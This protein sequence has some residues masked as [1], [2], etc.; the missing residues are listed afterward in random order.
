MVSSNANQPKIQMDQQAKDHWSRGRNVQKEE[1][2]CHAISS[3]K[4]LH[5]LHTQEEKMAKI[6]FFGQ[7]FPT[8]WETQV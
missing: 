8:A 5:H 4:R 3:A 6:Y 2:L 1:N 7:P